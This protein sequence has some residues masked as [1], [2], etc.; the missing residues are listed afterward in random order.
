MTPDSKLDT[1][2]TALGPRFA[3]AFS[4]A[5]VQHADQSRKGTDVPYISHLMAVAGLVLEAGGDEDIAIAALLHD[6]VED[7]GGAPVLAE[8]RTRFGDRVAQIVDGCTDSDETPKPPRPVEAARP[9]LADPALA[10][11][12]DLLKALAV[13]RRS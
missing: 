4:F 2:A 11:A 1:T 7:C 9:M 3:A 13:V 5:L 10:R 6:V 12:I 8:V